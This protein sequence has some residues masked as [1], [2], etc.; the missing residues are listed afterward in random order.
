V[1]ETEGLTELRAG[2]HA[3]GLWVKPI[4]REFGYPDALP[5]VWLRPE[6]AQRL[7]SAASAVRSDGVCLLVLDGW[8]PH[9]LQR[10]L[11]SSYRDRLG[12][13]TGLSGDELDERL[14][15]FVSPPDDS[16]L[17]AHATGGA[18]DLTLC[19]AAGRALDMGGEFDELT[20]RSQPGYYERPDLGSDERAC[21][22]RRRLLN[23][24]MT[25]EGFWR[26]PSEWWHFEYGTPSWAAAGGGA[27]LFD[28]VR[29]LR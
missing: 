24:A 29:E 19:D 14:K 16:T 9:A 6:V 4:Y 17:P 10:T 21:R 22:D 28:E 25:G 11:W 23:G 18:V 13:S 3:D 1:P 20:D 5:S 15:Q 2:E 26:F 8:R 12:E 7:V 27:P